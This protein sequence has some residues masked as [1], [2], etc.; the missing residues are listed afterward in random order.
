MDGPD[1]DAI[2]A[3]LGAGSSKGEVDK[4]EL[5]KQDEQRQTMLAQILTPDGLLRLRQMAIVK[6]DKVRAVEDML[7]RMAHMKQLRNRVTED[8]LKEMLMRINAEHHEETKIVYSRKGCDDSEEEVE[9][10]F[11]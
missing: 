10:D 11:E 4:A 8:E 3:Q 6:Q 5:S 7:I 1:L 9:Y 2:K